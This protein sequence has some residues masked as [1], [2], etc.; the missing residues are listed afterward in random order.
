M[1]LVFVLMLLNLAVA[2]FASPVPAQQAVI[3]SQ[4]EAIGRAVEN[5]VRQTAHPWEPIYRSFESSTDYGSYLGW[6]VPPSDVTRPTC[7]SGH[8]V[9]PMPC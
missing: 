6:H 5:Q 9:K 4:S 7:F 2:A 1:R 3:R 8:R